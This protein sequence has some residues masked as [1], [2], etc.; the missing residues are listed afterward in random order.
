[1]TARASIVRRLLLSVVSLILFFGITEITIRLLD[2]NTYSK[3]Q[4]FTMNR[5]LDYP[6]AFKRDKHLFWRPHP[7]KEVKSEFFD[8]R[9]YSFNS[10]GLRGNEFSEFKSEPRLIALGNSCTFGW[11]VSEDE[12]FTTYLRRLLD[13]K[14]EVINA[15]VPG[16]SSFQGRLFFETEIT[17]LK[18][19]ILLILFAWND[20]WIAANDIPDKNQKLPPQFIL[21]LQNVLSGFKT[22][23][24]MKKVLLNTFEKNPQFLFDRAN[25]KARVSLSDFYD[26]LKSIC[27]EAQKIGAIPTLLT[28][29]IPSLEKYYVPS[30][31]SP[32][33]QNHEKYNQTIREL[34]R[35]ENIKMIDLALEF[36]KNSGLFDDVTYDPVHFN[37]LGH[38][39]AAHLIVREMETL[40]K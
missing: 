13:D 20:Q 10:L 18:P 26:N 24:L 30:S 23:Q 1:M 9:T 19:D 33:H 37:G 4:F 17:E 34:A 6:E 3:N 27:I 8:G 16:Y 40:T 22:Y 12:I 2:I 7:N 15:G 38:R 39:I 5:D 25:P 11:G 36:D 32:L 31:V 14:Y 29:P 35:A 28:S 21:N